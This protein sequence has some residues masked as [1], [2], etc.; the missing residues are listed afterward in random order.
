MN[1]AEILS[2][3][4]LPFFVS[5][6]E[7]DGFKQIKTTL[8]S[9]NREL[10]PNLITTFTCVDSNNIH[11]NTI[12]FEQDKY[13]PLAPWKTFHFNYAS[14]NDIQL[15]I[16]FCIDTPDVEKGELWQKQVFD[17]NWISIVV[18]CGELVRTNSEFRS[19]FRNAYKS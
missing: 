14:I 16:P 19:N 9:W 13:N 18:I 17:T 7:K 4:F 15:I 6:T 10:H 1:K 3:N 8:S 12:L 11:I 2:F 5:F